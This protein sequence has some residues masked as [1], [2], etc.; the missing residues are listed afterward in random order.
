MDVSRLFQYAADQVPQLAQ[1]IGGIQRPQIAAPKGSSFD[2]GQLTSEDK[3]RIPLAMVRPLILRASFQ[4]ERPPFSDSLG[5]SR[6]VDTELR[7]ASDPA[8]RGATI[9]FVDAD[10]LPGALRLAGR[11]RQEKDEI[12]LEAYLLEGDKERGHF[13]LSGPVSD[14]E[15]LARAVVTKAEEALAGR[16]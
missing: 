16:R 11:Y 3:P 13:A 9:V 7:D 5:L 1:N 12:W 8:A 6:R 10:E 15:G 14:P 4:H 2:V